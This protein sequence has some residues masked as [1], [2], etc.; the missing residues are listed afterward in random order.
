MWYS[1]ILGTIRTPRG[2]TVDGIQHP[3][4]I[5]TCWSDEELAAINIYPATLDV[6]DQRYYEIGD[7]SYTLTDGTYIISYASTEKDVNNLKAERNNTVKSI[8][9]SHL[10]KSDWMVIRASEGGTAVPSAWTTY[11]AAVRTE[12]NDKNS[13]IDALSTLDDIKTYDNNGG[14]TAGWPEVPE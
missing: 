13:A 4:S 10:E 8:S 14:V 9:A 5:F 12:S 11:R 6:P 1:E 3:A 2:V 7:T